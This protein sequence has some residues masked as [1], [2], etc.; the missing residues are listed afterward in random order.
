M[1]AAA[2]ARTARTVGVPDQIPDEEDQQHEK[3]E[4]K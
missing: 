4:W 2:A 1:A 3:Q